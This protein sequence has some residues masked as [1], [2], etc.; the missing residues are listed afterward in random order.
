MSSNGLQLW[1]HFS[2]HAEPLGGQDAPKM[3]KQVQ[4]L[5]QLQVCNAKA[6][7][8]PCK[9]ADGGG[10]YLE[11]M[12]TGGKLWRI[13]FRQPD[14]KE[15]RLSFGAFPDVSLADARAKRDEARQA[16]LSAQNTFEHVARDWHRTMIKKWQPRTAEEILRRFE[17]Y[18]FPAFGQLP[19]AE[20]QA[21]DVL[22]D[23]R[24][25]ERR[26]ALEI[27]NRQTAN[28]SGVFRYAIR[29]GLAER[30]PAEFLREVLE[31][32]EKGHFA[33][34]GVDELPEFLRALYANEACM[35][36]ST[37]IAMKLMLLVFVR[38]SELIETPSAEVDVEKGEWIIP[39]KRMKRG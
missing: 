26:G 27:A 28:C 14:G 24:A 33:A 17:A 34:I 31:P 6:K 1:G 35:G 13:K 39:W 12:P 11:V 29:C 25:I 19:I 23:I 7:G 8:K 18:I 20:I 32:R 16:R 3:P 21:P 22:D 4:P 9:L 5:T 15:N 37:R 36:V 2:G 10:L 38:T 30:N